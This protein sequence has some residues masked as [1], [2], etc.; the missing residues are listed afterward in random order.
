MEL[1]CKILKVN[2]TLNKSIA[3]MS[4]RDKEY[5]TKHFCS[6][7]S[8]NMCYVLSHLNSNRSLPHPQPIQSHV[9]RS[10]YNTSATYGGKRTVDYTN[11]TIALRPLV[12]LTLICDFAGPAWCNSW[13]QG[14]VL[15]WQNLM[16]SPLQCICDVC[17]VYTVVSAYLIHRL[18]WFTIR[19]LT[20]E[21][22]DRYCLLRY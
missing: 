4:L 17:F 2:F 16:H 11:W 8:L 13:I 3:D 21:L 20:K 19:Y 12:G 22:A 7:Q 15:I 5:S 14:Q 10:K 9:S 18:Y 6:L 1:L